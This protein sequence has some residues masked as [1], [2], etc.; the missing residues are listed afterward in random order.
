MHEMHAVANGDG[1]YHVTFVSVV[2]GVPRQY[3]IPDARIKM[4]DIVADEGQAGPSFVQ[5][6]VS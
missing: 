5:F 3:S 2:N 6:T 1:T 4:E